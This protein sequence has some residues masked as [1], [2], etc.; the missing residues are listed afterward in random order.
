[1][2]KYS[3]KGGV[4]W[5]IHPE[6]KPSVVFAI[7]PHPECCIFMI[8]LSYSMSVYGTFTDLLGLCGRITRTI[9]SAFSRFSKLSRFDALGLLLEAYL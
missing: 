9:V 1:M 8:F 2:I 4:E 5:Q 7:R 3:M 6:A